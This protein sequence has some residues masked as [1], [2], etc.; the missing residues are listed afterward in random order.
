MNNNVKRRQVI[1][2]SAGRFGRQSLLGS[3][4]NEACVSYP[5]TRHNYETMI[6]TANTHTFLLE[7]AEAASTLPCSRKRVDNGYVP[8]LA[9]RW[10]R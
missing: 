10:M 7:A 5:P 8:A 2:A 4:A 9:E 6:M 3:L 1:F